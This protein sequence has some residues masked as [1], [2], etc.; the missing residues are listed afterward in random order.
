[1]AANSATSPSVSGAQAWRECCHGHACREPPRAARPTS[2]ASTPRDTRRRMTAHP[3]PPSAARASSHHGST[4]NSHSN[5]DLGAWAAGTRP[6]R[7]AVPLMRGHGV[8]TPRDRLRVGGVS[9][10][11]VTDGHLVPPPPLRQRGS[12]KHR[13]R[14]GRNNNQ[15]QPECS[16]H[17]HLQSLTGEAT[18]ALARPGTRHPPAR[19]RGAIVCRPHRTR[20]G[21]R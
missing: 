9:R 20:A 13:K 16:A 7:V 5:A 1:M 14:Y 18:N 12:R 17:R 11:P 8:R 2:P 4:A 3:M 19:P 15:P 6:K 21:D 10:W